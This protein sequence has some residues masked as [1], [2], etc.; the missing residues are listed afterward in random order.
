MSIEYDEYLKNHIN[1][2]QKGADF[3]V[4]Y[5]PEILYDEQGKYIGCDLMDVCS[6]HDNSKYSEEEYDAYDAYF[7]GESKSKKVINNFN[8]AWLNHIHKNPHHWQHWI[9]IEDDPQTKDDVLIEIPNLYIFEMIC[10]WWSFSW[11]KGDLNEIFNWYEEHKNNIKMHP[12]TI[13][14]VEHALLKIKIAIRDLYRE[15]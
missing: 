9:L 11:Q 12:N 13:K 2:V 15:M 5:L 8:L 7:Y 1:N 4:N 6:M 3:F 10:D 14:K